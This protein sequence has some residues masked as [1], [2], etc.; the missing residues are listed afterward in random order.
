LKKIIILKAQMETIEKT[1]Y[2]NEFQII[3]AEDL[4]NFSGRA[5]ENINVDAYEKVCNDLII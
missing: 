2:N 4:E 3:T 1:L 5:I